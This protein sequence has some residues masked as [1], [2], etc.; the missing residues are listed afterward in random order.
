MKVFSIVIAALVLY[1]GVSHAQTDNSNGDRLAT[2]ELGS[3]SLGTEGGASDGANSP[4]SSNDSVN[5]NIA[6]IFTNSNNLENSNN[7][8]SP[9]N[10]V[11]SDNEASNNAGNSDAICEACS[12]FDDPTSI[13]PKSDANVSTYYGFWPF[14]RYSCTMHWI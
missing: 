1:L 3:A 8:A 14:S 6:D 12:S 4:D 9:N 5:S 11:D 7:A 10:A 2:T 13:A